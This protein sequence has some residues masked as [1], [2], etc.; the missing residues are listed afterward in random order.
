MHSYLFLLE[1]TTETAETAPSTLQTILTG[2]ISGAVFAAAVTGLVNWLLALRRSRED[3]RA[4]KRE[5]F[6]QAYANY[7]EYREYPYVI[8]RRN[9]EKPAEERIRISEQ[10]RQTQERLNFFLAWTQVESKPIGNAYADLVSE[11]RRRAGTAM[12]AAWEDPPITED[13]H[14]SIP[15][16]LIDLNGLQASEVKYF[17]AIQYH[18]K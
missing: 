10:I 15:R 9:H 12:K 17:K 2:A 18:L 3:E 8:R 5:L 13:A 14:M 1:A 7:T 11:A 16:S 6:A 4:R